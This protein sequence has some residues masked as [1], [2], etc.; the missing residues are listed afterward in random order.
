MT[1]RGL[2]YFVISCISL[3]STIA[4]AEAAESDAWL[5]TGMRVYP[6]PESR[7]I[8]DGAVVV[9]A[10]KIVAVGKKSELSG[11]GGVTHPECNGGFVTAGFQNSHVHFI[12]DQWDGA[13][14]KPA[15][16]L[17]RSMAQMVTRFGYTT[18]VDIASV[19]ENTLALRSRVEGGEVQGPRILM[20]GLPLFPPRGIPIYLDHFPPGFLNRMPQPESVAAA[21]QVVRDNVAAGAVATKL[22]LV[23]PQGNGKVIRMPADIA[24]AAASEAHR[25]GTLVV[26]HPTDL[27]GV[28]AALAAKVDIL[29]HTTLG[30]ESLW[31]DPFLR[32]VIGSKVTLIPTLKLLGYEL[33][34]EKVPED[35][36]ARLVSVSVEQVRAFS[37]A[38]GQVLFGTDVGY[39][40]DFD[41][42][43]EYVLLARAGL[44]P[45][46]ILATLTTTP[47][48]RWKEAKRRGR[49]VPG[50]DADITVLEA[51]PA[52]DPAGFAKVRCT[53]REGKVVYASASDR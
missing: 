12:G 4:A 34:K 53:I 35:I 16:D 32:E 23:T 2:I 39:M 19:R 40:S 6:S 44:S 10:G 13:A 46:Q 45:M 22:F 47:A 42:A 25:A 28:R 21:V 36:A 11:R 43:E 31:P 7:A 5:L 48:D 14:R 52:K 51:D 37:K 41:P 49:L 9:R 33:K 30:A 26:A 1:R 29:A 50:M 17:S 15:S 8:D 3:I 27:E 18:V 24:I 20:V 38:G